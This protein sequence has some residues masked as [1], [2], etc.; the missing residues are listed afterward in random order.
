[1][2]DILSA[3]VGSLNLRTPVIVASG[4]WP[5]DEEFWGGDKLDGIGSVSVS[6]HFREHLRG[7]PQCL[8]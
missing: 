1:M 5:Y 7:T 6:L 2:T 4:V 8:C 3:S